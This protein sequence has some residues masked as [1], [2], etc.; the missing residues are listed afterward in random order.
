MREHAKEQE[1]YGSVTKLTAAAGEIS[2]KIKAQSYVIETINSEAK[3]NLS[4]FDTSNEAFK[5]ALDEYEN[6]KR[7]LLI[8]FL[9]LMVAVLLYYLRS[10]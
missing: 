5:S 3:T 8:L 9:L 1:L 7:N 6:D 10:P 2:S 4:K